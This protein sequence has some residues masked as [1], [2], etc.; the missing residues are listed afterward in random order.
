MK[1]KVFIGSSVEGLTVAYAIQENLSHV[2]EVTVWDQGVFDLSSTAIHDLI[3]EAE[4]SDF[5]IFPFTPDDVTEIRSLK[6]N[7]VRDNVIFEFALFAGKLGL[8]RVFYVIPQG[9][10]NLHLPTDLAGITPGK[11]ETNRRD[12]KLEAA[13]GP[14]CNQVRKQITRLGCRETI[15]LIPIL[16]HKIEKITG[17]ARFLYYLLKLSRHTEVKFNAVLSAFQSEIETPFRTKAA[18]LFR[19][20]KDDRT[21]GQVGSAGI[22]S[23]VNHVFP[24]DYNEKNEGSFSYVVEAFNQKVSVLSLLKVDGFE[25]EYIYCRPI[26]ERYVLSLH[27]HTSDS[28]ADDQFDEIL[29]LIYNSN[30]DIFDSLNTFLKGELTHEKAE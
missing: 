6:S 1:P 20:H 28:I 19:L 12:G 5:A 7:T 30:K 23:D 3:R 21:L 11:Y 14:F 16:Q 9:Q 27:F 15:D 26:A 17:H 4:Q 25:L 18:T 13:L 22:V 2:A 24:L 8:D 29:K 10:P